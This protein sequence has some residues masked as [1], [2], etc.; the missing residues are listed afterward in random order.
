M[1]KDDRTGGRKER[2]IERG[3]KSCGRENGGDTGEENEHKKGK[4][5]TN[6]TNFDKNNI[7]VFRLH[8][9]FYGDRRG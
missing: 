2:E 1:E 5:R 3:E 8:F 9:A 6:I 4:N 7:P